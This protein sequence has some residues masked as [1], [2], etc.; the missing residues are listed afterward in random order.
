MKNTKLI[1]VKVTTS[2]Y[3]KL[4]RLAQ[5]KSVGTIEEYGLKTTISGLVREVLR[6]YLENKKT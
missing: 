2:M 1:G 3:D 5:D 4:K 6:E